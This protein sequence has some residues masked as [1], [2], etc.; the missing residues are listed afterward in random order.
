MLSICGSLNTNAQEIQTNKY[1]YYC[2]SENSRGRDIIRMRVDNSS[3]VK[4]TD[5]NG[6]NHYPHHNGPVLS[7]DG[8]KIVFHSDTEGHDRY[9]IW[10]MNIDGSDKKRITQK[11]G[12]YANWSPDGKTIIF[13]GRRNGVWEILTIPSQGGKE[14]IL[15]NNFLKDKKPGWGAHLSYHPDGKSVVFSYIREKVL[16]SMNLNTKEV[17]Q[18][19]PIGHLYTQPSYSKDGSKIA[20][21][22]KQLN[23]K[24]YDL[25]TISTNDGT[26]KTIVNNVISY[27]TPS[28]SKSGDSLLFSGMVNGNQQV[29]SV[30][31][32]SKKE[33]QLTNSNS[34][35]A[36]A[37]W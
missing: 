4:L 36:L 23:G 25:I 12:L 34:F 27:A 16:Y 17:V 7:P 15:S 29:F 10:T 8:S 14:Q 3:K 18:L 30:A 9:V 35:N 32:A 33:T 5:N 6:N 2:S 13:S 28:W 1:I 11:E 22:R 20:V 26:I 37:T 21:N 31:I 24:G 19:S